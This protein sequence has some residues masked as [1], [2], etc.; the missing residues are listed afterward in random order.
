SAPATV[1]ITVARPTVKDFTFKLSPGS[2]VTID[3][4]AA[5]SDPAGK[6]AL[7]G[8]TITL[9]TL[10]LRGQAPV[11]NGKI[12][13]TAPF[14]YIGDDYFTYTV[15]DIYGATSAPGSIVLHIANNFVG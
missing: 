3:V 15:T 14:G 2:S 5:A 7:K 12:V 4:I 6:D 11:S 10:P 9:R 13:Y 1:Y 8:A